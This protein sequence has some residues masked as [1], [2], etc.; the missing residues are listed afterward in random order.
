MSARAE[1]V[2]VSIPLF[3]SGRGGS[4]P[5]SA[6]QLTIREC[7]IRRAQE[8]NALWHS[9]LPETS[10]Q[11]LLGNPIVTAHWADFEDIAYAV[12][13]WTTPLAA[14]RLSDGWNALELRRFAIASDAPK[15]TAT[16][17]LAVMSRLLSR[18]YPRINRLIS[19]Q[20]I[21]HHSGTIYKAAGWKQTAKTGM[22]SWVGH[23]GQKTKDQIN[24]DKLRWEKPLRLADA[25]EGAEG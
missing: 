24:T 5:T 11:N 18:K 4:S 20:S 2:R 1:D 9:V 25:I 16:R 17:M 10:L 14:N 7:S 3:H 22:L 15:N 12:A 21:A 13:I 8:L 19:Y 6:L 23:H